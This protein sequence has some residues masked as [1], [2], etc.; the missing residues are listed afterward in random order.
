ME[1]TNSINVEEAAGRN[2]DWQ[3]REEIEFFGEEIFP[4]LSD[5]EKR[6][7]MEF[8]LKIFYC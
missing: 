6:E 4:N 3:A 2:H 7:V 5:K 1:D 8:L